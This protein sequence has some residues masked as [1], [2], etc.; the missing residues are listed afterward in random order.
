MRLVW[1]WQLL[2]SVLGGVLIALGLPPW[3][4]SWVIWVAFVPILVSL[5]A[6]KGRAIAVVPQGILFTGTFGLIAFHW[7]WK[8]HRYQEL[9]TVV[10]VFGLQGMVWSWFVW[11]FCNLPE[12]AKT[13]Q[14]KG[15]KGLQ[16]I[17]VG[18][19]GNAEAWRVSTAHLRLAILIASSWTFLEWCRGMVLTAWNPIGLPI[20]SNLPLLQVVRVTGPYGLSFV[21]VFAS[22]IIFLAIRRLALQPGRMTWAARFDVVFTLAMLFI[23]AAAGF[24]FAEPGSKVLQLRISITASPSDSASELNSLFPAAAALKSDLLV[25]RRINEG[26]VTP[27]TFSR[28]AAAPDVGVITGVAAGNNAPISGYSAYLPSSVKSVLSF[29]RNPGFQILADQVPKNLQSFAIKDIALLPLINQEAMSLQALKAGLRAPA[30]GFIVLL[31]YPKGT[32]IEEQQFSEN[33]RCWGVS[34]G[35]PVIFS[36]DRAGAFMQ[37]A[38]GRVL[39]EVA[40]RTRLLVTD[41]LDFPLANDMTPY[42]SFGDWLPIVCG[43]LSLVFGLR[44]RLSDFYE[45]SRRFR[46]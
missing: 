17:F 45:S 20:A 23:I 7:L 5:L 44:Q 15:K 4:F 18:A 9:G 13:D 42:G 35:R 14:K 24:K 3:N 30:Q 41:N 34:L 46:T 38:V 28:A 25:W 16:P 31:D 6:L 8:E 26:G 12:L 32:A 27:K 39:K 2:L 37:T 43:A 21:A 1:L 10:G 22:T 19:A 40:P 11:R 33:L 36:S 29:Q